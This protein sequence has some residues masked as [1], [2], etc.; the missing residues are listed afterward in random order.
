MITTATIAEPEYSGFD[1]QPGRGTGDQLPEKVCSQ[2][3]NL[4]WSSCPSMK[5]ATTI[6]DSHSPT[7]ARMAITPV[8]FRAFMP[9]PQTS[10]IALNDTLIVR[11]T[12]QKSP[13]GPRL[14]PQHGAAQGSRL[15]LPCSHDVLIGCRY[16]HPPASSARAEG[17]RCPATTA[18]ASCRSIWR[19]WWRAVWGID[20]WSSYRSCVAPAAPAASG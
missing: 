4:V 7:R 20:R 16:Q 6:H 1:I 12:K 10:R 18:G 15:P 19:P 8:L 9:I 2:N 11:I 3:T 14:L 17:C 13:P 5:S